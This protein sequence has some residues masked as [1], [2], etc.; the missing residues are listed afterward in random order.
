LYAPLL[1]RYARERGLTHADAEEIRDQCLLVVA[2]KIG[3]LEYDR[4][5]GGFKNWL[6]CIANGKVVD[7]LRRRRIGQADTHVLG[8][9]ADTQP[10]PGEVW[11]TQWRYQHLLYCAAQVK[12]GVGEKTY[13]MFEL[14]AFEGFGVDEVCER[15]GVTRNQV[16][17]AKSRVL[18]RIRA[19]V[20][21][22]G[23]SL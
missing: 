6:Y 22:M 2:R 16:Y 1:Y 23:L 21:E 7:F 9:I 14:L 19:R 12:D 5:R 18:R 13:R 8:Q 11:D 10:L 4:D 20:E 15:L 17:T 3:D